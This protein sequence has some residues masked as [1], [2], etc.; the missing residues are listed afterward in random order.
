MINICESYPGLALIGIGGC[1]MNMMISWLDR[2]PDDTLC[3]AVNRD[4]DQ[5]KKEH[6]ITH[7]FLLNHVSS[8]DAKGDLKHATKA[9]IQASMKEQMPH[10]INALTGK[11]QVIL[12]AGLGGVTG[13]WAS[14]WLCNQLV[15]MDMQVIT[16]LVMPFGFEGKRVILAEEA[17]SGFDG[18]AHRVLCFNDYLIK[19]TPKGTSV[20]DAFDIM[21]EKAFDLMS[22]P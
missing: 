15:A 11:D 8:V 1:G 10:L 20:V 7:K 18:A 14:Q 16:V 2:L 9:Q 12:L 19:H 21:N 17:L 6:A 5:L 13:T 3:M 22:L 4:R